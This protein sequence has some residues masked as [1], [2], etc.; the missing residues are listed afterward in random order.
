MSTQP[1]RQLTKALHGISGWSTTSRRLVSIRQEYPVSANRRRR[2]NGHS[3]SLVSANQSDN[4]GN[5]P[6]AENRRAGGLFTSKQLYLDL[7]AC[8]EVHGARF[9]RNDGN[10]S[11][12]VKACFSDTCTAHPMPQSCFDFCRENLFAYRVGA[13]SLYLDS[14]KSEIH[15]ASCPRWCAFAR[16]HLY[17][18][19]FNS[20]YILAKGR[21]G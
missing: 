7:D 18:W 4:I 11:G 16:L 2:W 1:A 6:P 5:I 20:V 21:P 3:E 15:V 12:F 13:F 14:T 17:S 10:T 8:R 19:P 9:N